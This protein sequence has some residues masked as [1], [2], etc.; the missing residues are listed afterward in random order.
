MGR[1]FFTF[2][3][4]SIL[5]A[6]RFRTTPDRAPACPACSDF[7]R[8]SASWSASLYGGMFALTQFYDPPPARDHGV[9]PARPVL[10]AEIS[11]K[12]QPPM[13][14]PAR[15][16]DDTL[17][18]LFLDM[19]AAERGA[20]ENTLAAYRRDLA[21]FSGYLAGK[22][23]AIA[24]ADDRRRARLSRSRSTKRGFAAASVARRLSA[25]R[26]LYRFLYAEGQR[27]DDPAAIVE[28]PKRGRAL[29]KVLGVKD[30]D[31]LLASARAAIS[32]GRKPR[33]ATAGG[34]AQCTAGTGLCHR[35]ARVGAGVAAGL[36]GGAQRPHAGGARQGR[37]GTARAAQRRRQ[38]RD[39]G[40]SHA[41]GGWRPRRRRQAGQGEDHALEVA[42]SVVRRQ[43]PPHP[44][45]FCARA[46][47][48]RRRAPACAPNR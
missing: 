39:D 12:R 6:S 34:A 7:S 43:R 27:G 47:G 11:E 16:S 26:Q 4:Q 9:D 40:V 32:N 29:P 22:R 36:G 35:A 17:I 15:H 37:Q 31:R 19:L 46:E 28:G 41:A 23:G 24:G 45:A 3:C 42:V 20:G 25:I 21:D 38:D 18:E 48:A 2:W 44:P 5:S 33:R 1:S 13:A 14:R 10:E 8:S 30:V